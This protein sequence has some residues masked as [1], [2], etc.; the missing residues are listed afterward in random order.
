MPLSRE[1]DFVPPG[2]F[3]FVVVHPTAR[4]RCELW[5][6]TWDQVE[7]DVDDGR[8]HP[9]K[10]KVTMPNREMLQ[11]AKYLLKLAAH[12]A[13]EQINVPDQDWNLVG[14]RYGDGHDHG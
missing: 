13:H 1:V 14:T 8:T 11:L 7:G 12:P 5:L 10:Y 2:D 3:A 9:P 6:Y 4:Q